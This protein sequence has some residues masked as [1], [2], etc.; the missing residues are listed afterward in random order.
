MAKRRNKEAAP[1]PLS[2]KTYVCHNGHRLLLAPDWA[3]IRIADGFGSSTAYRWCWH[4]LGNELESRFPVA[5]KP[6]E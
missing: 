2:Q 4:C 1:R 3:S 6:G 5:E